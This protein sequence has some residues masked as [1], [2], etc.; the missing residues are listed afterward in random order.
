V[1]ETNRNE[2]KK[3]ASAIAGRVTSDVQF[4]ILLVIAIISLIVQ[5]I[6]LWYQCHD[7]EPSADSVGPLFKRRLHILSRHVLRRHNI[8]PEKYAEVVGDEV[9][10]ELG[11]MTEEQVKAVKAEVLD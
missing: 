11:N 10:K 4:S 9:I 2:I 3:R 6:R 8:D 7:N 5:A 1:I